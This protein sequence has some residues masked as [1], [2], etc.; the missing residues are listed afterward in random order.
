MMED[1][2]DI[3]MLAFVLG[4][5][6]FFVYAGT[7]SLSNLSFSLS[8]ITYILGLVYT[9]KVTDITSSTVFV[10][11]MI[12]GLLLIIT[13][14][15][16][17]SRH[18]AKKSTVKSLRP[19]I[20]IAMTLIWVLIIGMFIIS[21]FL[22][23]EVEQ[24]EDIQ[25][26]I[27]GPYISPCY[28]LEESQR[29]TCYEDELYDHAVMI[30][31]L[32]NRDARDSKGTWHGTPMN[33]PR[34]VKDCQVGSCLAFDASLQQ[35]VKVADDFH[36]FEDGSFSVCAW[37]ATNATQSQFLF[38]EGRVSTPDWFYDVGEAE[39]PGAAR[40][41]LRDNADEL[42]LAE[43]TFTV[44]GKGFHLGCAGRDREWVWI[45]MDGKITARTQNRHVM[46]NNHAPAYIGMSNS[47]QN[48][49]DGLIDEVMVF[50]ISLS[51]EQLKVLYEK[52]LRGEHL[53]GQ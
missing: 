7:R 14:V 33:S 26:L 4:V 5:I 34:V 38:G 51:K 3:N 31:S 6:M 50:D 10:L 8:A 35:S 37:Y 20:M 23:E 12:S 17:G 16:V 1:F 53:D 48:H 42:D 18:H 22:P 13:G 2:I 28:E 36:D 27:T 24:I 30:H 41:V 49:W 29:S 39:V 47:Q 46:L 19:V 25:H 44:A 43:D 11:L 15:Y 40:F 21:P 9:I 32:E 52:G 45:A